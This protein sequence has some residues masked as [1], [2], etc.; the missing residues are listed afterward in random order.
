[1]RE[2]MACKRDRGDAV[3]RTGVLVLQ[4]VVVFGKV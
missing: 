2:V 4:W 3:S 1:M